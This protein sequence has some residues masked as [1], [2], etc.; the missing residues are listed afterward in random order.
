[1]FPNR[2]DRDR[3]DP[4]NAHRPESDDEDTLDLI[5]PPGDE[6]PKDGGMDEIV[7]ELTCLGQ[8]FGL[9]EDPVNILEFWLKDELAS[10]VLD[11]IEQGLLAFWNTLKEQYS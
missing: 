7:R 6:E 9:P 11:A 2:D 5:E 3:Y 8:V 4:E 10:D 1:V